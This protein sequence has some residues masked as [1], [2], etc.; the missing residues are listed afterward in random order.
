MRTRQTLTISLPPAML[1][2]VEQVSRAES[3][4]QS[5]LVREALRRYF[6]GFP[7]VAAT[8]A[9]LAALARGRAEFER[10]EYVTLD[11][12]LNDLGTGRHKVSPKRSPKT[13]AKR[14]RAR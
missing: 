8:P 5:E 11:T 10:G 13:P 7:V 4:T 9:E 6:S 3:R 2:Q 14:S 12:L 1:K